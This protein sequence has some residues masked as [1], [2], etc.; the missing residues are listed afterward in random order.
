MGSGVGNPDPASRAS[1]KER[2]EGG[3]EG[4]EGDGGS[5]ED[6]DENCEEKEDDDEEEEEEE[7][8]ESGDKARRWRLTAAQESWRSVGGP[9]LQVPLTA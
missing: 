1:T 7:D 2:M 6:D 9:M 5:S 4:G 3:E 8:G